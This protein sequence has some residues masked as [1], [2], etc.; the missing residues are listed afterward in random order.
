VKFAVVSDIHGNL[1][2]FQTTLDYLHQHHISKIICL[3]D[4]V[5]YGPNPNE[6]VELAQKHC[7][8]TVMGNHDHA[9]LGLTDI[10]YFNEYARAAVLWTRRSLHRYLKGYLENLPMTYEEND[11]LFVHSSPVDPSEWYYI[12]SEAEAR[13]NFKAVPNR[14]I[15][16]GHS[17]VPVVFSLEKGRL[18]E[19]HLRLDIE[20]DRYI[21]NVGSVGQPRDGDPR[22]SFTI[23][24]DQSKT[25]EYVRLEY[26]VE[27]THQKILD[28]G[29]PYFLA[30]RILVGQ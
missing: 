15:F 19:Q 16:I 23:V 12:F 3:G 5:G 28:A 18:F 29:L 11:F 1:E 6:C 4:L 8:V 10:D 30:R 27:K 2:A 14:V 26:P 9:V 13:Q 20:N 17:H 24:D 21:I 25:V 7:T 22:S